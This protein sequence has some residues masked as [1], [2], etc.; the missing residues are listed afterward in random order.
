M[1]KCNI[2]YR[3]ECTDIPQEEIVLVGGAFD[4]DVIYIDNNTKSY[5]QLQIVSPRDDLNDSET[6]VLHSL[7]G[8]GNFFKVGVAQGLTM[9]D[10]LSKLI[11]H[12]KEHDGFKNTEVED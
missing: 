12:Y 6:Y 7:T 3:Q 9:D 2:K 10:V 8:A 5:I 11:E 4:K 1:Q